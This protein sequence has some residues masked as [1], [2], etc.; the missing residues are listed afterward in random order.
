MKELKEATTLFATGGNCSPH[1][2][3]VSLTS[4]TARSLGNATVDHTVAHLLFTVVVGRIDVRLEHKAE[5]V[6]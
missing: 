4:F 5:I 1:S 2:F 6:L 3:V